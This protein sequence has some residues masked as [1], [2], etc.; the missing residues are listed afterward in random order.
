[1]VGIFISW[2]CCKKLPQTGWN[3][4]I[5]IY[6]FMVL[7]ARSP[8]AR[9]QQDWL[10]PEALR[11]NLFHASLPASASNPGCS[12][13]CKASLQP[14]PPL[15]CVL[16]VI[17]GSISLSKFPSSYKI[18]G[19][20][21]RVHPNPVW[22]HLNLITFLKTLFPRSHSQVPRVRTST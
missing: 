13:V 16:P 9:W 15:P 14:L 8:K 7:N 3:K 10:L 12:L 21:I 4:T 1:M 5:G 17:S 6:P 20:W 11:E 18:M 19:H 22:P 2:A